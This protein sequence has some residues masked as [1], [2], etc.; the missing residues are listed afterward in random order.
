MKEAEGCSFYRV[1]KLSY[2]HVKY[3]CTRECMM[4]KSGSE[5]HRK[6]SNTAS[7]ELQTAQ[8]MRKPTLSYVLRYR[9]KRPVQCQSTV[10]PQ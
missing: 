3:A 6:C 10:R 8:I 1:Y 7:K 5:S 2:I 4:W 9:A